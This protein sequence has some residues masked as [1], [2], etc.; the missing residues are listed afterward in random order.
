MLDMGFIADIEKIR[1]ELPS[2]KQTYTFSATMNDK[3]KSIIDKHVPKYEFIKV[4]ESVTVDKINHS[5][6]AVSHEHKISNVLHL[7]DDH[8]KEKIVIFTHTKR[9]TKTL[10]EIL[11]KAGHNT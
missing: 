8:K 10:H 3:M 2:L 1:K 6:L 5:Y 4:G 11:T 7:I 9:N